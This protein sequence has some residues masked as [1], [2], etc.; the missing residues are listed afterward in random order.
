M[1]DENGAGGQE[2]EGRT[3]RGE[4]G[5]RGRGIG[6]EK[7]VERWTEGGGAGS[8]GC[9]GRQTTA[10]SFLCICSLVSLFHLG[11]GPDLVSSAADVPQPGPW[12]AAGS[13]S[14][15]PSCAQAATSTTPW[16][17]AHAALA[18]ISAFALLSASW[19]R[20]RP[21][22][23]PRVVRCERLGLCPAVG[24]AAATSVPTSS[25]PPRTYL[26]HALVRPG[27]D[28]GHVLV[29]CAHGL[30]RD[31]GRRGHGL[32]LCPAVGLAASRP[33][34][35]GPDLVSSAADVSAFA[36]LS[37]SR[38]SPRSRPRLVRCGRTSAWPSARHGLGLGHALPRALRTRR[39]P[40]PRPPWTRSR[41][42]PICRPRPWPRHCLIRCGRTSA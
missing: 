14:A 31:L 36:Q 40:R 38:P 39:W 5:G 37:A 34:G 12:P 6:R 7:K 4:K 17:I 3:G 35:L 30:G 2:G 22:P 41:P 16:C 28:L 21:R 29:H 8:V 23:R 9:C 26:G 25:R 32:G 1:T 33:R 24:L 18:A 10:L 13:D 19:P 42:L 11:L 15:T 27:R 20:S